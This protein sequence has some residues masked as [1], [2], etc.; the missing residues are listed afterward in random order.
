MTIRLKILLGCLSLTL[1]T[2]LLGLHAQDADRKLGGVALDIYD[3]AFMAMSYLRSAEVEFGHL[4][5]SA[6]QPGWSA[7]E[8][9]G[10]GQE[11]LTDL[12]VARDRAMSPNGRQEVAALQQ[13]IISLL[14]LLHQDAAGA[15]AARAA[16]DRVVEIFAGD[17]YR[18]RKG[19][20]RMVA[21][22]I[23]DSTAAIW[24]SLVAALIITWLVARLIAPPVRDAVR[25]AQS[26]AAGNLGTPINARGRGETADL[27]RALAV[28]QQSIAAGTARIKLLM[29][30]MATTHAGEM[31]VQHA[32]M[33]AAFSNMTQGLCL[34]DADGRLLV[35]NRRFSEMFAEP[36]PGQTSDEVLASVGLEMLVDSC[37]NGAVE[38]VS[39]VLPDGRGIA[40][41]HSPVEGGGWV[42]TYEDVSER[43]AAE[44]RLADMARHDQ[45]TGLPNRLLFA[46]H[47]RA[48]LTDFQPDECIALL[49]ID[50]D[51]F[52]IV[53]DTLGHP[54]GD[55]LLRVVGQRLRG[56]TRAS[57]LVV[58]LGGDEFAIIQ[59]GQPEAATSLAQRV[60]GTLAEPFDI[61]GHRISIGGSV[62][63]AVTGE[64]M[65]TADALLK[66]ADLALYRAKAEGRGVWRF[67]E[68]DMDLRMQARRQM[69]FDLRE[70][71]AQ[72]QFEV[73]YQPLMLGEG[74]ISGFEALV[75]WRHPERGLIGPADFIPL[76]EEV[77]LIP[78]IGRW[79]LQRACT[80]AA[81]WPAKLKVAVNLS[82]SQFRGPLVEEVTDALA[83][84]GLPAN[85]LELEITESIML[86]DEEQVL[87][88]LHLLRALGA[89]ISMDD[90]GTGYSSLG[91][92]RRFPF[93]KIKI[94][95]SFVRNMTDRQDCL[96]IVRAVIGLGRS[97]GISVNAEG[98]E[99]NDQR[100]A[101]ISEGCLELQGYLF[102][103]P[104][105]A[106]EV[107]ELLR[108]LGCAAAPHEIAQII[109]EISA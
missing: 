11:V 107:A 3:N 69:E 16:F 60:I 106:N 24:V 75:R 83:T 25:V 84:S 28:M 89:R 10:P 93:D 45:V 62:G 29:D 33:D 50:L 88:T 13:R 14:P 15:G 66:S 67:F 99:T 31:A 23:R 19:V 9:A 42:A 94:D 108:R 80:D 5:D 20:G 51:R 74:G 56:C 90:F 4:A 53:N 100:E 73:F 105:P 64:V 96:A 43:R 21:S 76:A 52:K 78:A 71:V 68:A 79:V 41:S 32:Q 102:S 48:L 61:D 18:Y 63:I 104:R 30:Q 87:S 36:V 65:A 35:A 37:R 38:T 81:G 82:P 55:A 95:Q 27:L 92:L 98:V 2:F 97:L 26:I 6:R 54:I 34:F 101:L 103:K 49:C 39:C 8:A 44:E 72:N 7:R 77:G 22:E 86:A 17:A 1:L 12:D 47:M 91:Y 57:D 59:H 85:L 46:E 109:E 70:A 58:R 40:V